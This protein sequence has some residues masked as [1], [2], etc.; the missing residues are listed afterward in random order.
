MGIDMTYRIVMKT[1]FGNK[2]G[3]LTIYESG[4]VLTGHIDILGHRTEIKDCKRVDG[5][6]SFSGEFVTPV[7]NIAFYAQGFV[8]NKHVSLDVKAGLQYLSISGEADTAQN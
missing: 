4:N 1:T 3:R 8:D 2:S 5:Q 7:R 6:C